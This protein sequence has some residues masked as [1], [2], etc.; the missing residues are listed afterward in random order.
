MDLYVY[1]DES[2]VFDHAHGNYFVFGGVIFLS[3]QEKEIAARRYAAMERE[4]RARTPMFE[5]MKEIKASNVSYK[6]K[7]SFYRSLNRYAKFGSVMSLKR[8]NPWV[9]S[10]K[11]SKQRYMDYAYKIGLKNALRTLVEDAVIVPEH[12][13]CIHVYCDEHTTAT[14]GLY[15][16]REALL[17][18]FKYG[19]FNQS[20]EKY[21]EPLFPR[22]LDV[23]V[24]FCSSASTT[25]LRPADFIAN[26]IYCSLR[27]GAFLDETSHRLYVKYLP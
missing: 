27:N 8:L 25:L 7:R 24:Q 5:P 21:F 14:N 3:Q 26:H 16:M 22:V 15:E 10:S 20:Y 2:G 11:R 9:F 1:S 4:F 23:D 18:E 13:S 12:V 17:C 19:T 6:T